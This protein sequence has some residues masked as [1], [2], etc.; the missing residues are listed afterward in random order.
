MTDE[1]RESKQGSI[2]IRKL[3]GYEVNIRL[4]SFI[5]ANSFFPNVSLVHAFIFS[6]TAVPM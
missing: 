4:T 1:E 2:D 3:P 6:F 5:D